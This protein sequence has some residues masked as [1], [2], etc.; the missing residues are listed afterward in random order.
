MFR[1]WCWFNSCI[2]SSRSSITDLLRCLRRTVS[3]L[4]HCRYDTSRITVY[5]WDFHVWACG[6]PGTLRFHPTN[7]GFSL[8]CWYVGFNWSCAIILGPC[9]RYVPAGN[10]AASE[11]SPYVRALN[12]LRMA[13]PVDT[14]C[15][16]P[17]TSVSG[18]HV[19]W[20]AY[21]ALYKQHMDKMETDVSTNPPRDA[22]TESLLRNS[23]QIRPS[24]PSCSGKE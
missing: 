12:G 22:A 6:S 16:R 11:A 20:L 17:T 4:Q 15:R 9:A 1:G 13:Y 21:R 14:D 19:W 18:S 5:H 23:R 7:V 8:S 10:V 3:C 2:C 24:D